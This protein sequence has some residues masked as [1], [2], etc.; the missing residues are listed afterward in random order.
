MTS[1]GSS[2]PTPG[3]VRDGDEL[4]V[5]RGAVLSERCF[6]CG[7]P[8]A[9]KPLK[10]HLH[11]TNAY[12][13][14]A[15]TQSAASLMAILDLIAYAVFVVAFLIDLPA[16]GRRRLQFGLCGVHRAQRYWLRWSAALAALAGP[17]LWIAALG[18]PV[19]EDVGAWLFLAGPILLWLAAFLSGLPVGPQL[20]G[21]NAQ[22]FRL[23]GAGKLFLAAF[24]DR[25][26]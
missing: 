19:S 12:H 10:T 8:A 4:L 2:D 22:V 23:S 1:Q 9:G 16:A 7:R 25:A 20:V 13:R 26:P 17:V 3:I 24:P 15:T 21:E 18:F 6:R 5:P 11:V 14:K